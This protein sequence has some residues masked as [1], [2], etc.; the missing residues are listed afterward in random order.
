ML[1]QLHYVSCSYALNCF[2]CQPMSNVSTNTACF[3]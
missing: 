3:R 2:I 1:H